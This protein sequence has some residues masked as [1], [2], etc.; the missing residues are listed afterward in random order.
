M[1]KSKT[2]TVEADHSYDLNQKREISKNLLPMK[3]G[4]H[5]SFY[6]WKKKKKKAQ[7]RKKLQAKLK[8]GDCNKTE[9]RH[10]ATA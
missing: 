4:M 2:Y 1:Q 7:Q 5:A 3:S 10:E 6:T 8:L 9:S